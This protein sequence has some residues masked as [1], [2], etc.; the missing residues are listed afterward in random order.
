M[1][2][3]TREMHLIEFKIFFQNWFGRNEYIGY[4]DRSKLSRSKNPRLQYVPTFAQKDEII[5]K[6]WKK[7]TKKSSTFFKKKMLQVFFWNMRDSDTMLWNKL[8]GKYGKCPCGDWMDHLP[9]S[10]GQPWT[11]RW[12]PTH[13]ILSTWLLNAP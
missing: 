2:R 11:F 13:P 1:L 8:P 4:K 9:T 12:P 6:N 10:S 7:S 5:K 3:N